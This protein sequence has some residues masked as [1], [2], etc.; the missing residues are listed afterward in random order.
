MEQRKKIEFNDYEVSILLEALEDLLYK[1]AMEMNQFKGGPMSSGRQKID[2]K[3]S[4]AEELQHRIS[5]LA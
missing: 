4:F 1:L 2:K 5:L 3:Q